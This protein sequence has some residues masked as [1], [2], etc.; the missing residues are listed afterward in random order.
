M[1]L[2]VSNIIYWIEFVAES[3]AWVYDYWMPV[4]FSQPATSSDYDYPIENLK[5]S[6]FC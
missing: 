2:N 5:K 3:D 6:L 4:G 1:L